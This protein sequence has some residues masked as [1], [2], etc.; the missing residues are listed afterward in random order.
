M[1]PHRDMEIV[2]VV[3]AG[4]LDHRDSMGNGSVI[5]PGEVQRM[6]A[7]TGMHHTEENPSADEPVHLLQIWILPERKRPRA[8]LRAGGLRSRGQPRPLGPGGLQGRPR[9]VADRY[10]RTSRCGVPISVPAPFSSTAS[11][12]TATSGCR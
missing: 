6:S 2:T 1:H 3:V 11:G 7:G 10:T 4:A 8:G 5:R 9:R 12:R